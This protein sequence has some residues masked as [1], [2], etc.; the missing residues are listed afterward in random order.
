MNERIFSLVLNNIVNMQLDHHFLPGH[1]LQEKFE[2]ILLIISACQELE[3]YDTGKDCQSYHACTT[4]NIS[5]AVNC[6]VK[7]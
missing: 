6:F 3:Y 4:S 7:L 1:A 5:G 2:N